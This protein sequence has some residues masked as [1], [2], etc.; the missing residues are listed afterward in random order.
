MAV[1]K[2][3]AAL[4]ECRSK[5]VELR[6]RYGGDVEDVTDEGLWVSWHEYES[7]RESIRGDYLDFLDDWCMQPDNQKYQI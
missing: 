2:W 5:A 6:G 7:A 1:D 4:D 3:D